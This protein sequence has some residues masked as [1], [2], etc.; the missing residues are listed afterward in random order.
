MKVLTQL[1][2]VCL[3]VIGNEAASAQSRY[4]QF[5][6]LNQGATNVTTAWTKLNT[7][8][9]AHSFTKSDS[10]SVLEVFVNSRFSVGTI[11]GANGVRF[12]VRIDT[13]VNANFENWGSLR[14]TGSSDFIPILAVFRNIPAGTH[15]VSI[16]A[17]TAP[18]GT[19]SGVTVDPGGWGGKIIVK[20]TR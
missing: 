13:L 4:F 19:A 1:S 14:T 16:W 5:G 15:T 18:A 9:G 2:L 10:L 12:R 17:Q 20:E 3:M 6:N 8:T 7:T 11:S